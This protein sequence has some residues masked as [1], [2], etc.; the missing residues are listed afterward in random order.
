[1]DFLLGIFVSLTAA[2]KFLMIVAMIIGGS[3]G[4]TVGV[5]KIRSVIFLFQS[6]ILRMRSLTIYQEK[7]V[8]K[9]KKIPKKEEPSGVYLPESQKTGR[10]YEATSLIFLWIPTLF[11]A[12]IR[13]TK[14]I[15]DIFFDVTSALSRVIYRCC[16]RVFKIF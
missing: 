5:L 16:N 15:I 1:M 6:I 7:K 12:I 8:L 11:I 4:S 10:L 9:Q 13:A 3:S 2:T 14:K